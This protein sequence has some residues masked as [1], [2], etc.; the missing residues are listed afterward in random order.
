MAQ[1]EFERTGQLQRKIDV[2]RL[3]VS[4][5]PAFGSRAPRKRPYY[6]YAHSTN[7]HRTLRAATEAAKRDYPG[8]KFK[9]RFVTS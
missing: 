8:H 2:F 1:S 3:I 6:A 5:Q 9:A 7:W 4:R